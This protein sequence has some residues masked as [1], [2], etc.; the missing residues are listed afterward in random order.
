MDLQYGIYFYPSK[1]PIG[2]LVMQFA[3]VPHILICILR[4]TLSCPIVVSDV[5]VVRSPIPLLYILMSDF[6]YHG[7]HYRVRFFL[8]TTAIRSH[9]R[10]CIPRYTLSC[11]IFCT[12]LIYILMLDFVH[13][14][15]HFPPI[16]IFGH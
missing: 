7:I 4:Y 8:C 9:V 1:C 10:F 2:L 13:R 6:V 11:P 14:G 16:Y 3:N 5:L 12:P 15:I